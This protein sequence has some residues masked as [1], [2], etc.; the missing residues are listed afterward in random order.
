MILYRE[1]FVSFLNNSNYVCLLLA[2]SV[3]W[4]NSFPSL[5]KQIIS[6]DILSWPSVRHIYILASAI[7]VDIGLTDSKMRYLEELDE[8]EK[9]V[10]IVMDEIYSSKR[11]E[12]SRS[13]GKLYG[14][15]NEDPTKTLFTI[16]IKS[17]ASKY[18]DV[19]V[20][21]PITKIDSSKI[22]EAFDIVWKGI[23]RVGFDGHSSNTKFYK[24]LCENDINKKQCSE[25]YYER[26]SKRNL[27]N[28]EKQNGMQT[29]TKDTPN[30]ADE[31]K[32]ERRQ[33]YEKNWSLIYYRRKERKK[34]KV[35][36]V[37]CVLIQWM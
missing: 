5:Y 18:Q 27:D 22:Y 28:P 16:M 3:L 32:K 17:V 15:E 33:E 6:E 7:S 23:R 1:R 21:I 14:L 9:V 30:T 13:T 11:A 35:G 2:C 36:L 34:R 4:E 19:I 20:M 12:Y 37:G 26:E 24:E 25:E 8:R 31:S 29:L 10:S